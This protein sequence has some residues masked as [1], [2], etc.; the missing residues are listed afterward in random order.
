MR[1]IPLFLGSGYHNIEAAPGKPFGQMD[2]KDRLSIVD[3]S[4]I[5]SCDK[6]FHQNPHPSNLLTFPPQK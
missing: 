1:G 5:L 2:A 3:Q 4:I 6:F